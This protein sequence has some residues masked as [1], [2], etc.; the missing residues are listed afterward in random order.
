MLEL[1]SWL[2]TRIQMST[3]H[4]VG[5]CVW[6]E[7]TP[8]LLTVTHL[9]SQRQLTSKLPAMYQSTETAFTPSQTVLNLSQLPLIELTLNL[10][11]INQSFNESFIAL[12]GKQGLGKL[13]NCGRGAVIKQ[14][15]QLALQASFASANCLYSPCEPVSQLLS[16]PLG[17]RS[18]SNYKIFS[19]P[20][21]LG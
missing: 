21:C 14:R 19:S 15:A 6:Q 16:C 11:V 7:G 17:L 9:A 1:H 10:P 20:Q 13:G 5:A 2:A 8:L 18:N 12:L 3:E 4:C